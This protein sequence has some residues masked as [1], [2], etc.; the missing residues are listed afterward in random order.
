MSRLTKALN[1]S[2]GSANSKY[3]QDDLLLANALVNTA[4]LASKS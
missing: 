1:M 3:S 4:K 2:G